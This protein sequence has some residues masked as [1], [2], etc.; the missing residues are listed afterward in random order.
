LYRQDQH[1]SGIDKGSISEYEQKI[2]KWFFVFIGILLLLNSCDKTAD[3]HREDK[4]ISYRQMK[5]EFQYPSSKYGINCWWWWLNGNV[6]KAS[7]GRRPDIPD[8]KTIHLY[9]YQFKTRFQGQADR[10]NTVGTIRIVGACRYSGS[11]K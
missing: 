11:N 3:R 5:N 10:R 9:Q 2:D 8:E 1:Y 6:N 7:C 4:K